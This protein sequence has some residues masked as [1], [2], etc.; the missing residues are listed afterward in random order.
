MLSA[1]RTT[2]GVTTAVKSIV[3]DKR[4][5][6]SCQV[7][8]CTQRV[9]SNCVAAQVT[10]RNCP[11]SRRGGPNP[12]RCVDAHSHANPVKPLRLR[13]Y[14]GFQMG[15]I[16]CCMR[17]G[18]GGRCEACPREGVIKWGLASNAQGQP[19]KHQRRPARKVWAHVGRQEYCAL[20]ALRKLLSFPLPLPS[21][22]AAP[23][24]QHVFA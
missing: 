16:C 19:A 17:L 4:P 14:A 12:Q 3:V 6:T 9:L 8:T 5:S 21:S 22:S 2:L 18:S 7:H 1:G 23:Q 20:R 11:A 10:F 13:L 15:R 24:H